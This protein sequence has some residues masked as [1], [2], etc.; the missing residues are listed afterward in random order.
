[1]GEQI[2]I[3]LA[4]TDIDSAELDA[5]TRALRDELLLLD[6]DDV[7]SVSAGPAPPGAKA[8]DLA[9]IGT[10]IVTLKGTAELASKVVSVVRAWMSRTAASGAEVELTIGEHSLKLSSASEDQQAALIAEFVK[11]ASRC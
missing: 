2:R 9:V 1:M 4:T 11:A 6:V 3:D 8:V 10:L 5:L 7:S